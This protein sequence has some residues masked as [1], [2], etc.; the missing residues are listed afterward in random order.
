MDPLLLAYALAGSFFF[1]LG[2]VLSR[3]GLRH[4]P[5]I[6]GASISVPTTALLFLLGAPFVLDGGW[7]ARSALVFAGVGC[8]YPAAATL[9]NFNATRRIGPEVTGA[10]GNLTPLFAALLAWA[11]IGEVPTTG[12]VLALLVIVAGM[13][14]LFGRP[15]RRGLPAWAF[16]LPLGAALVRGLVQPA[17]KIGLEHWPSPYAATLI[18]YIASATILRG[19]A[20]ATGAHRIPASPRGR[21]WF[22]GV[23]IANGLAV[24]FLYEALALGPVAVVAPLSATYPLVTLLLG[25]LLP[26]PAPLTPLAVAGIL[27]TVTGVVLLLVA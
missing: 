4:L 1:A 10:L 8:L 19:V 22:T 25:R 20:R 7:D 5:P 12:Q 2:L 9:L 15:W 3:G 11:L 14:L 18:G 17:V 13:A 6:R 27:V 16:A 21:L 23:G 24:M 26:N